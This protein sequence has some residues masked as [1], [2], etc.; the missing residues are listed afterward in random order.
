MCLL[1]PHRKCEGHFY[2]RSTQAA[3]L[4]AQEPK[5][6]LT[7]S[8]HARMTVTSEKCKG[9]ITLSGYEVQC[10]LRFF[11]WDWVVLAGVSWYPVVLHQYAEPGI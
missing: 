8:N 11:C 4:R 3:P 7:C 6:Q 2:R 5:G 10:D 1:L 9:K